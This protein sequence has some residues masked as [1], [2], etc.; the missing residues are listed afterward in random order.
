MAISMKMV[1]SE[2]LMCGLKNLPFVGTA[3]EVVEGVRH[4]TKCSHTPIASPWP[5][6]G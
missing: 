2:L 3:V 1:A 4:V 5:K 6:I